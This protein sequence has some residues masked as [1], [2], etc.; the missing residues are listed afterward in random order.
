MLLVVVLVG[1]AL[2]FSLLQTPM[3]QASIKIFVAQDVDNGVPS[4]LAPDVPGL[5]QFARTA[6]ELVKA[7][8]VAESVIQELN[9]DMQPEEL[10]ERR[11]A[12][13]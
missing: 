9:L 1:L 8:P 6:T 10:L 3:Y 13:R 4:T 5:Q 12:G 2:G 7:R 11:G